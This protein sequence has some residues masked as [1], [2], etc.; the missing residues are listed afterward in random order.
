MKK[1]KK[2]KILT[3]ICIFL[4]LLI[5]VDWLLSIIIYNESFN[6][7]YETQESYMHKLEEFEGLSRTKYQFTSNKGQTLAGYMYYVGEKDNAFSEMNK[8]IIVMSHGFGG[9]GHNSYMDCANEFAQNGYLVFAFDVTGCDESEGNAVGGL[10]QGVIDLRYAIS[11]VEENKDFPDLPIFLFGHSWG[12]Y[13]VCSVLKYH[14]EVKAVIECSGFNTSTDMI[15]DV[16]TGMGGPLFYGMLP[17]IQAHEKR[18]FNEYATISAMDGFAASNTDVMVIHSQDD[19][20]VP[21]KYGYD[22]YYEKYK[23]D[24]RF[25]FMKFTDKG[26]NS[27]LCDKNNQDILDKELF[28]Q[29]I[30]FYDSHLG[31]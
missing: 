7:R 1:S 3:A 5:A 19:T 26:H 23:D 31:K 4:A 8:G 29:F 2:K 21:V 30:E 10:P 18:L 22:I 13:S 11:F 9:G 14:P 6:V 20:V 17:F 12:G 16:G 24:P 15:E 25:T 27:I 28:K